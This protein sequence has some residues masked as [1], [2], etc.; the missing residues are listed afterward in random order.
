MELSDN[1][2]VILEIMKD[3]GAY[4]QENM[5]TPH[6]LIAKCIERNFSDEKAVEMSVMTLIDKDII[7]YEMDKDLVTSELWLI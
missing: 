5:I 4:G 3:E 2:N 1:E 7:E 6:T